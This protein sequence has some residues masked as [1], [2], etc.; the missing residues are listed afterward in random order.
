MI[1][2]IVEIQMLSEWLVGGHFDRGS[3]ADNAQ[4]RDSEGLPYVPGRSVRGLLREAA[5]TLERALGGDAG[6]RLDR[7][8]GGPGAPGTLYVGRALLPRE[9]AEYVAAGGGAE[10]V[11]RKLDLVELISRTAID[12]DTGSAQRHSLRT[13]EVGIPG[14]SFLAPLDAPSEEDLAFV[15][16]AAGLVRRI[17][18]D[19]YRGLGRCRLQVWHGASLVPATAYL[20]MGKGE[21]R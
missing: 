10:Q 3:G 8:F 14:L 11:R 12:P 5:E 6:E 17:G 1:E 7:L 20:N 4:L 13:I 19:R 15:A 9:T 21:P 16:C 2:A 18:A